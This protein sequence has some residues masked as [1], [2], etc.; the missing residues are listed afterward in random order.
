MAQIDITL[1]YVNSPFA[2]RNLDL[3]TRLSNLITLKAQ[4]Y[5]SKQRIDSPFAQTT[6]P[7]RSNLIL[8]RLA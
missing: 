5:S 4:N 8:P 7:E 6:L 3:A 2:Q 1:D